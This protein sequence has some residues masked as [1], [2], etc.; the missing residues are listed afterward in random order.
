MG[1]TMFVPTNRIPHPARTVCHAGCST[2]LIGSKAPP[3]SRTSVYT[4]TAS[5]FESSKTPKDEPRFSFLGSFISTF[6]REARISSD[7]ALGREIVEPWEK[8]SLR[9]QNLPPYTARR[10]FSDSG[11]LL[12][13]D[14]LAGD[15]LAGDLLAGDLVTP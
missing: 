11:D 8:W 13:G 4:R 7:T 6:R 9:L 5:F 10:D 3:S 14:L 12:A 15:L 2:A 1:H